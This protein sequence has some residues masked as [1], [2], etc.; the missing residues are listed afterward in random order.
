M[1]H[2]DVNLMVTWVSIKLF[3]W[4]MGY[5]VKKQGGVKESESF[6]KI[7]PLIHQIFCEHKRESVR[8]LIITSFSPTTAGETCSM[9]TLTFIFFLF[10]ERKHSRVS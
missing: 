1:N 8:G 7:F 10:G 6:I 9:K 5:F 2:L 4:F 3:Q